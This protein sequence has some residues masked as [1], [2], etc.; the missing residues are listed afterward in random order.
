METNGN[1]HK[2]NHGSRRGGGTAVVNMA[3]TMSWRAIQFRRSVDLLSP[4]RTRGVRPDVIVWMEKIRP[5]RPQPQ[6]EL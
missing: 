6:P 3:R 4:S 2:G 1:D 5:V